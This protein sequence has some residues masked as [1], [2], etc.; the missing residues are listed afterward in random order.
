MHANPGFGVIV[1]GAIGQ[2]EGNVTPR[3]HKTRLWYTGV[4]GV[5]AGSSSFECHCVFDPSL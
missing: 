4:V 3:I 1:A 5:D 2:L